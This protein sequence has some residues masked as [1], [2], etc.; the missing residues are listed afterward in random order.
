MLG[1]DTL[2]R[3]RDD[4]AEAPRGVAYVVHLLIPHS[5]YLYSDECALVDPL[6][7]E[8]LDRG[9]DHLYSPQDR[10][11]L[12]PRYLN[13]VVC[14]NRQ[15]Q[16]LFAELKRLGVYDEATIIVHGDHGSRTGERP[17]ITDDPDA[18]TDAD[19]L[20]HYATL[21]AIKTP[22]VTPGLQG[23]PVALQHLFAEKFLGGAKSGP[24]PGEV[25]IRTVPYGKFVETHMVWPDR[26]AAI[27]AGSA[28]EG[29]RTSFDRGS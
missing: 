11:N 19:R 1:L 27:A 13:Q 9:E 3:F 5:G 2:N 16:S 25:Y 29:L 14:A 4:I 6:L 28:A 21:L 17:F 20:D 22:G 10:A 26:P 7:W 23:E 15:M 8:K 12:Y 18:M 24:K